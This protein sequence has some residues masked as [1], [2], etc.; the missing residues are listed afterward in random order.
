MYVFPKHFDGDDTLRYVFPSKQR[1]AQKAIDI[2]R[3][4]GRIRRLIVFG[5]A[6]TKNCGMTSDIDLA[7]DAPGV[8][9]DEFPALARKF[10]AGVD[11]EV[12]VIDYNDKAGKLLRSEIDGKGVVIYAGE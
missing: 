4:D 12:D 2:A 7:V 10:Y 1:A 5:S 3:A 9:A 6:V 8:T 11:S